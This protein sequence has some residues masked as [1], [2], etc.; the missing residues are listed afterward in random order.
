MFHLYHLNIFLVSVYICIKVEYYVLFYLLFPFSYSL[1]KESKY[2]SNKWSGKENLP[3]KRH[4]EVQGCCLKPD[5]HKLY[6]GIL[7]K[8]CCYKAHQWAHQAY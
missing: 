3:A 7:K 4:R 2:I 5:C 6:A 8:N 1:N